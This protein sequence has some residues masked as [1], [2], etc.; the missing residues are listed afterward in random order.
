[1]FSLQ[2]KAQQHL[3]VER[4][5][6]DQKFEKHEYDKRRVSYL[7]KGNKNFLVKYNPVSLV[8]GGLLLMYQKGI[9]PQISVNC[10]YEIS[11]SNFSKQCIQHYGLIKGLAL[12]ADRLTRCTQFTLI[13]LKPI[14]FNKR[15]KII[16]PIQ[17]YS[18]RHHEHR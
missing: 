5:L 12:T 14:Q 3:D 13:D 17:Q 2:L 16:D 15:N 11:C 7:F 8:F 10:P 18:L 1:M 4:L 6:N 9:S